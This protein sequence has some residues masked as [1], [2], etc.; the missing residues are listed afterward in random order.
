M[1]ESENKD[2]I[3]CNYWINSASYE[4]SKKSTS[5]EAELVP[6]GMPIIY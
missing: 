5:R 2:A 1:Y 3:F 6:M 4:K